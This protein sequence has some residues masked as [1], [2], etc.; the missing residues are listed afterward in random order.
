V[1]APLLLK[2]RTHVNNTEF[3]I[4]ELDRVMR[5][6]TDDYKKADDLANKLYVTSDY[7]ESPTKVCLLGGNDASHELT[8]PP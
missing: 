4:V 7:E 6:I 1:S 2:R 8:C 3:S 5:R